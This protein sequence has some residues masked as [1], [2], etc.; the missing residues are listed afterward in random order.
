[1]GFQKVFIALHGRGGEDGTLQGML[2][3]MGLPYT[4]SGVMASALSMDKLRSKLLW[5][6]CQ[7]YRSRR[8][9][10]LTRA[11]FEKGPER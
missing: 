9:V 10:A 2:E 1:M 8:G 3:L 11:E 4:G 5:A 6:R 7:F